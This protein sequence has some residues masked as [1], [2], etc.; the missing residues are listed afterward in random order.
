MCAWCCL[1]RQQLNL[2]QR[3]TDSHQ[4]SLGGGDFEKLA[5]VDLLYKENCVRWRIMSDDRSNAGHW[6]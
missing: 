3:R 1:S 5:H 2:K 4:E 6:S